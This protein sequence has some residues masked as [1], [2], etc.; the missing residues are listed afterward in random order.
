M[1]RLSDIHFCLSGLYLFAI[2]YYCVVPRQTALALFVLVLGGVAAGFAL[3]RTRA[4]KCAR[5]SWGHP[6]KAD[7]AWGLLLGYLGYVGYVI[8]FKPGDGLVPPW[9]LGLRHLLLICAT[10]AF[11]ELLFRGYLLWR[12]QAPCGD[13]GAILLAGFAMVPY[14][15]FIQWNR[16][17]WNWLLVVS[18]VTCI[19]A[20]VLGIWRVQRHSI[21]SALIA[22]VVY[23]LLVFLPFEE[24]PVWLF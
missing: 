8:M 12:L 11:E 9:R 14:K 4:L 18:C 10:A 19:Y 3:G 6:R 17:S 22:H 16:L 2:L 20:I 23:D 7:V 15:V 24:R 13:L 1:P 5:E 21:V